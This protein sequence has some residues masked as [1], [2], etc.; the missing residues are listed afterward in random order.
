MHDNSIYIYIA[1]YFVHIVLVISLPIIIAYSQINLQ[2]H[3]PQ[4]NMIVFC[5]CMYEYVL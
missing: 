2:I 3:K 5:V 4:L 1:N